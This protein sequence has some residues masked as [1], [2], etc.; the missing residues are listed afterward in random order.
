MALVDS[1]LQAH[2]PMRTGSGTRTLSSCVSILFRILF[3]DPVVGDPINVV[4]VV[5]NYRGS[6]R[7]WVNFTYLSVFSSGLELDIL[8]GILGRKILPYYQN[9]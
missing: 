7:I 6:F 3:Q 8:Y 5:N 9:I 2:K 4:F 1:S